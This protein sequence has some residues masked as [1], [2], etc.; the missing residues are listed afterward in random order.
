VSDKK[1]AC[2]WNPDNYALDVTKP[3][4]QGYYD[5]ILKLYA[6]WGVDFIKADCVASRPY[7][8]DDIR[9]LDAARRKTGRPMVLSLSP[10]EAPVEKL[11]EL[12][13]HSELWRISD[14]VWDLWHSAVAYPQGLGDQFPRIVKW[15]PLVEP[16][17]WPDG[18]LLGSGAGLEQAAANA[19]DARGAA[20]AADV[21]V[22]DEIAVDGRS[23]PDEKRCVDNR[24]ADQSRSDRCKSTPERKT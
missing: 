24:A 18:G 15:A 8:G 22:G 7:N 12:R 17:H 13:Q 6:E 20:D 19:I 16:G 14:D 23:E 2:P 1:E 11:A 3:A 10:G 5:S 21:V 4:A 9:M